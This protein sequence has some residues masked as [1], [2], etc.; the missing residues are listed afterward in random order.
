[1]IRAFC[2]AS[3]LG[4]TGLMSAPTAS[5]DACETEYLPKALEAGLRQTNTAEQFQKALTEIDGYVSRCP[6]HPWINMIGAD[7]DVRVYDVLLSGNNNQVTQQAFDYLLRAFDRS[8]KFIAVPIED[9]QDNHMVPVGEGYG[10]VTHDMAH[11]NRRDLLSKLMTLAKLGTVHPYLAA[12]T[13][14]AC[15]GWLMSDSQTVG[16]AMK[17]EADLIFRPFLDAAADACSE[18]EA[19]L[20]KA[21]VETQAYVYTNLVRSESITDPA[22][23]TEL[24]LAARDARQAFLDRNGGKLGVAMDRF[25]SKDLDSELRRHGVDPQAGIL[26]RKQW[27]TSEHMRG[28]E[29]QFSLA[30]TLSD[31]WA[32]LAAEMEA[33]TKTLSSA[34]AAY[35]SFVSGVLAEGREAGL[36]AE[37]RTAILYALAHMQE[38]RV[39]SHKMDGYDLPPA[40]LFDTLMKIYGPQKEG[41]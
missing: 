7:M 36:E 37:T 12:E 19:T 34:G 2:L 30:W 15:A 33:G 25:A 35:T 4:M 28:E 17:T 3:I 23:V 20:S 27:F 9:R 13:P 26:P 41:E 32:G 40:W 6:D 22:L 1:M 5:A 39:R 14:P 18:I 38:S 8:N 29:M 10:C 24:L 21:P 31:T 11:A 16:Y